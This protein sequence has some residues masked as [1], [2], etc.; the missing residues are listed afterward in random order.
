MVSCAEQPS[1][2]WRVYTVVTTILTGRRTPP[3]FARGAAVS[4]QVGWSAAKDLDIA[5]LYATHRF[6][7]VRLAF[8]L[9]DDFAL[10]EDVVQDAFAGFHARRSAVRDPGAAVAYLRTSVVNLSRSTLRRRRTVRNHDR[11]FPSRP[12][13]VAAADHGVLRNADRDEV[14]AAL[15]RLPA[16]QREVLILRYWSE[17]T[18]REVA[19]T[20]G[21]SEGTVKSTSSRAMARLQSMLREPR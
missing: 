7:L 15:Q 10:A 9:V 20:L 5:T 12:E 1:G 13:G 19:A 6:P 8:L 14:I 11:R 3:D 17:L 16:R 4:S 21:I 18:E 2:W